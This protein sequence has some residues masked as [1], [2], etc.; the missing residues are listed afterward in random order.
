[1][2]EPADRPPST[3]APAAEPGAP[4]GTAAGGT[5]ELPGRGVI[6]A[7]WAS[8]ALFCAVAA[9]ATAF[10]S[11]L[12]TP[13]AVVDVAL[14]AAGIVV[15]FRAYA[16]AVGR[17]RTDAI[18]IGGLFF[19]ADSAPKEVRTR[20]LGPLGVQVVVAVAS[21]SVR[22]YTPVAF[23]ILVPM[24]GLALAGLW[25]ARHGT[26]PPRTAGDAS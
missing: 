6:A 24:L 19:L 7:S 9:L 26:F 5:G 13:A 3:D 2:D 21:A 25:G 14:F 18:G 20:L 16:I 12:A 1:M 8:T 22:P 11:A 10:P 15:F 4:A 17:S 23:G